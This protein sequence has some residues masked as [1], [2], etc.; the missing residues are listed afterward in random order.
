LSTDWLE[1]I[2][3]RITDALTHGEQIDV[4]ASTIT[5][6]DAANLARKTGAMCRYFLPSNTYVFGERV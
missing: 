4:K 1:Y 2:R 6:D 3:C 5:R